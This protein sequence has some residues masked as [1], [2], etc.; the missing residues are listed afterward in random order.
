[1]RKNL[2]LIV[3]TLFI[4]HGYADN[5]A[6]QQGETLYFN[7]NSC[8]GWSD[9]N[10]YPAAVF[11]YADNAAKDTKTNTTNYDNISGSTKMGRNNYTV[12]TNLG[13]NL[14]SVAV[15]VA[16]V[17]Y[18]RIVRVSGEDPDWLWNSQNKMAAADA[19]TNN[20]ISIS[21]WDN[22]GTWT[23]NGSGR[24]NTCSDSPTPG[25]T[26]DIDPEIIV[27]GAQVY[28]FPTDAQQR[29]YYNRPYERY[30]A[31]PN[32]C[33]TNG[34][35]LSP[36]DDQKTIQSEASHQT[37]VQLINQNSYVSWQ[38]NRAGDG[39]TIRFCLP[40]D[41]NG[42]GTKGKVAIYANS[43]KVGEIELNSW[44][45][46]QYCS[47]TYPT[48]NPNNGPVVRMKFDEMHLRLSRTVASGEV[49]KV[50]K[51]DN[52]QTPYTI[53]FV[54]LEP[55]VKTAKPNNAAEF[56]GGNLQDFIN[57]HQGQVIF[58][59][60]GTYNLDRYL[61]INGDGTQLIGAGMWYTT[62]YFSQYGNRDKHHIHTN[63]SNVHLEGFYIN[64]NNNQRYVD[65]NS[66]NGTGKGI[67]GSWGNNSV[68][69]NC[70]IEHFE[71]GGWI[72]NYNGGAGSNLTI[73]HCR[74][75]NNYAD[76]LNLAHGTSNANVRYC[77][78]RNNGDDEMASW[79][80]G[81]TC[82][83]NTFAYCTAE[84]NWRASAL[85]IFGGGGHVGHHLY[86]VDGLES[87][88]RVNSDFGGNGFTGSTIHFHDI[89]IQHCGCKH[90][91][92]GKK[93]TDG[94]II[95]G[96]MQ[97]AFSIGNTRLYNI[98]NVKVEDVDIIGSRENSLV[99]DGY[100][101]NQI[102]NAEI[103]N[104]H[105]ID[106]PCGVYFVNNPKGYSSYCHLT[107]DNIR[108]MYGGGKTMSWTENTNCTPH[109]YTADEQL[110][111]DKNTPT[112]LF[113]NGRLFIRV[114]EFLYDMLGNKH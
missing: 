73:E 5:C 12:M 43:D 103:I 26:P 14:F 30:E 114:G 106:A 70:W 27:E 100:N 51:V 74:F 75:R 37:A 34:T 58:V 38:V 68:I 57:R 82:K 59:P 8:G 105:L 45:A 50:V 92:S 9:A 101:S 60:E 31:E 20:C 6:F 44:W 108:T 22:T 91:G 112:R 95:G 7:M 109:D 36:D 18:I 2:F 78:F 66:G 84:N 65:N 94:D 83:N 81:S 42:N 55:T 40:D 29:G 93:G 54:E 62:L 1:M 89:T 72:A 107:F 79:T 77:S 11:Y 41:S 99:F 113:I 24:T 28:P 53:D 56:T 67:E 96:N 21:D 61:D 80:D 33:N 47:G 19:G 49:L 48:N 64:A 32:W 46:W 3:A 17:G 69:K 23:T 63:N 4:V 88:V 15:P 16:N 39:L 13:N 35:F 90:G 71:C 52:N 110:Q 86:I 10:A 25:P 104:V 111:Q 76:G 85:G 102:E 87:G 98:K 97:G